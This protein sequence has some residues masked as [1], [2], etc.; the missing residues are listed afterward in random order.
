M[1]DQVPM[2]EFCLADTLLLLATTYG[3]QHKVIHDSEYSNSF[4]F[5]YIR[6]RFYTSIYMCEPICYSN[7]FR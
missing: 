6:R 4:E 3:E 5:V 2:P 1:L 7:E